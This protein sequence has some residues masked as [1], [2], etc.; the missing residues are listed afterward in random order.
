MRIYSQHLV[1]EVLTLCSKK[2]KKRCR[3]SKWR[4]LDRHRNYEREDVFLTVDFSGPFHQRSGASNSFNHSTG[5][6]DGPE[7]PPP[8]PPFRPMWPSV[9]EMIT[10][11]F[12]DFEQYPDSSCLGP[13]LLSVSPSRHRSVPCMYHSRKDHEVC[14]SSSDNKRFYNSEAKD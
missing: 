1:G 13:A 11:I 8:S 6:Y 2:K 3:N 4:Y 14:E 12:V 5:A 10:F 7:T 9:K